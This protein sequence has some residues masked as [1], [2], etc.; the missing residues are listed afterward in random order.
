MR[1]EGGGE[2]VRREGRVPPQQMTIYLVSFG[3][4]KKAQTK[5]VEGK[6][7]GN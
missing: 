2:R 3:K 4:K 7:V 5:K 6:Q 1:R